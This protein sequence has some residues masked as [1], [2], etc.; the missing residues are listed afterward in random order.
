MCSAAPGQSTSSRPLDPA[1]Q[2]VRPQTPD[3]AAEGGDGTIGRHQQRQHV[4]ALAAIKRLEPRVVACGGLHEG[5]GV[6][7]V[8]R[9]AVDERTIIG[10]QGP[11]QTKEPI[12]P[13]RRTHALRAAHAHEAVTGNAVGPNPG[14]R[15]PL[16]GQ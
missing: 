14:G 9:M 5:E 16:P 7:A 11:P 8:P 10:A 13:P 1:D 15:Q 2:N 4:E 3:I 6:G 12:V